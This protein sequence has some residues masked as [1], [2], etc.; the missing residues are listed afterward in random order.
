[1]ELSLKYLFNELKQT[2]PDL[3]LFLPD[4]REPSCSSLQLWKPGDKASEGVLTIVPEYLVSQFNA[5][6]SVS[7]RSAAFLL[8]GP[9][10]N[11]FSCSAVVYPPGTD[12]LSLTQSAAELFQ[13]A[14]QWES[15]LMRLLLQGATAQQVLEHITK[16]VTNPIYLADRNFRM[17][18]DVGYIQPEV[19]AV[20]RYQ[21]KYGFLPP[22][23]IM[24]LISSGEINR[25]NNSQSATIIRTTSFPKPYIAKSILRGGQ[26]IGYFFIIRLY[27][28]LSHQDIIIA[29]LLGSLLAEIESG[30]PSLLLSQSDE[31]EQKHFFL[32]ILQE[33]V[34]ERSKIQ[35]RLNSFGWNWADTYVIL[36]IE[37]GSRTEF[38]LNNMINMLTEG[39]DAI[40][41]LYQ[42]CIVVVYRNPQLNW[43]SLLNSIRKHLLTHNLRGALSEFFDN[44][45]QI[46]TFY[47]QTLC[48]LN[49]DVG[50]V[51]NPVRF[52]NQYLAYRS[53]KMGELPVY[54]GVQQLWDYDQLH[55]TEYCLSLYTWLALERNIVA[56]ANELYLHRNTMKYRLNRIEEIIHLDLDDLAL[57]ERCLDSLYTLLHTR[58]SAK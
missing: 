20:W 54:Q 41:F 33:S 58:Q 36:T 18:A 13:Q 15:G 56:A 12:L 34:T 1:M 19:S 40:G 47:E 14:D 38:L 8:P 5:A 25:I 27:Q 29:D 49:T 51:N 50:K 10:T 37:G 44:F 6:F 32:D 26:I 21:K 22:D 17:L 42:D 43:S 16:I 9:L 11:D 24:D 52:E 28:P 4:H 7:E 39:W 55:D 31:A 46:R 45:F 30:K 57:R 53:E 48:S 3:T 2:H 23:V 35:K